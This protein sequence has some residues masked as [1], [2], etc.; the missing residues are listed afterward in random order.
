MDRA[1]DA[2]ADPPMR[3]AIVDMCVAVLRTTE[4]PD[5]DARSVFEKPAHAAAFLDLLRDCRPLP[6]VRDLIAEIEDR[7]GHSRA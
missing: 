4:F 7:H 2:I 5:A 1:T 6:V 3:E